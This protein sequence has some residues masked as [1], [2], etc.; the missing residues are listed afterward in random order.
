M[1]KAFCQIYLL[2]VL[3]HCKGIA[4][5]SSN[6]DS[7]AEAHT[8]KEAR[9]SS[10]CLVSTSRRICTSFF[11][12]SESH[13]PDL[14]PTSLQRQ[15]IFAKYCLDY[16][17]QTGP[18]EMQILC[19]HGE[20]R[21][22][23][24]WRMPWTLEYLQRHDLC[25]QEQQEG[26]ALFTEVCATVDRLWTEPPWEEDAA[27]WRH[28]QQSRSPRKRT[29]SPRQ[30]SN[31][32]R[33]RAG[34]G[35]M[36]D[37]FTEG[38]KGFDK[39]KSKGKGVEKG[40]A[41]AFGHLPPSA[42]WMQPPSHPFLEEPQSSSLATTSPAMQPFGRARNEKDKDDAELIALRN[43]ASKVRTQQDEQS[44]DVKKALA[45]VEAHVR[46]DDAKSYHQLVSLVKTAK[47]KLSDI[48]EQ[49]EAFRSQWTQYLDKATKMWTAHIDSYEEGENKFAE[50]R[51]EAATQLQQVRGQLHAIHIRTMEG[52]VTKG[53]LQEGQ[54]ALDAT[55][56]IDDMDNVA[57]QPQFCQLKT[58]LKGAA[59]LLDALCVDSWKG[60]GRVSRRFRRLSFWPT[61]YNVYPQ[62]QWTR[63]T[64]KLLQLPECDVDSN[65]WGL[66]D[67]TVP[68]QH[69][70]TKEKDY[71]DPWTAQI[72]A[73]LL[74]HSL[75][76]DNLSPS[77]DAVFFQPYL[78]DL[79]FPVP[80][81][82]LQELGLCRSPQV[83]PRI[84]DEVLDVREDDLQDSIDSHRPDLNEVPNLRDPPVFSDQ[85][86]DSGERPR[87]H[88]PPLHHF[89]SWVAELWDLLQDEGATE[90]LEEGPIVYV[91][92]YYL[93]HET[94]LRQEQNRPLRLTREY[95][96]WPTLV[97]DVWHDF[98][99]ELSDFS[100]HLV[101]PEPPL[102]VTQGTVG[103]VL[104]VQHPV[105]DQAAVLTTAVFDRLEGHR[106]HEVAHSFPFHTAYDAVLHH[107]DAAEAC[108]ELDQ[109]NLGPCTIRAGRHTFPRHRAIR[110]HDGLGLV[111]R[112]PMAMPEE[113]WERR[114]FDNIAA[115]NADFPQPHFPDDAPETSA[116][117][118]GLQEEPHDESHLMAR[119]P[120]V[121]LNYH[122][123]AG[124]ITPS[125]YSTDMASSS[126]SSSNLQPPAEEWHLCYV[127]ALGQ[128]AL[129]VEV[130][131]QDGEELYRRVAQAFHIEYDDIV[132]VHTILH[133]PDDILHQHRRC[134][135]L[136]RQSDHPPAHFMRLC[137][138][139]V[140]YKF[141]SS[142]PASLIERKVK[143]MPQRS[144][145]DSTIRL[146][147][148][149]GHCSAA[150]DRCWLWHDKQY[151]SVNAEPLQ[152]AHGSYVRLAVPAHPEQAICVTG[153]YL[154]PEE[155][156]EQEDALDFL[157]QEN[158]IFTQLALVHWKITDEDV[159]RH[160]RIE[161][162]VHDTEEPQALIRIH[163]TAAVPRLR[164]D[165]LWE[166][167]NR[168]ALR[169][170]GLQNEPV[171]LFESWY[172]NGLGFPRCSYSRMVALDADVDSWIE[173]LRQVWQDRASPHVPLELAIVHPAVPHARHGGHL[174]V[175]Q[176]VHP[177][178]K[179]SLL[180]SMWASTDGALQDRFAQLVPTVIN[181]QELIHHNDLTVLCEH[182]DYACKAY[183]GDRELN[184]AVRTPVYHGLHLALVIEYTPL[185]AALD[186]F[187]QS[188]DF[189]TTMAAPSHF[190]GHVPNL[191]LPDISVMPRIVQDLHAQWTREAA[192]RTE[193]P[194]PAAIRTWFVDHQDSN[195]RACNRP[196]H[197]RLT[198][199]YD[200]WEAALRQEWR[201]Y[202]SDDDWIDYFI[203][204][205]SPPTSGQAVLCHVL[206]VRHRHVAIATSVLSLY[207]TR[208]A[209]KR[210][211]HYKLL[212]PRWRRSMSNTSSVD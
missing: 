83:H 110:C 98:F 195:L 139:D 118:P 166:L 147:G 88:R 211:Q 177:G 78:N 25:P 13:I 116:V 89:P 122:N 186:T 7:D 81:R 22:E 185:Q 192:A 21:D 37:Q 150:P 49:W 5:N 165:P 134:L 1:C 57:E 200:T 117:A 119:S 174:I 61:V 167:W 189:V 197:V 203:V 92:S 142:G 20:R 155:F 181:L 108:A 73:C 113:E 152:L 190:P 45:A 105:V 90:L 107:A 80:E 42:Q 10:S 39:G 141:D 163:D 36:T 210:D 194:T 160:A 35:Q 76:F 53:E 30:R 148:Y 26:E 156:L 99:D 62:G 191:N 184:D 145:R 175:L 70:V 60:D 168:P 41:A 24:L 102:S 86:D 58:D 209:H 187:L 136:Q 111:V 114:V 169:T 82:D 65:K 17:E 46:K 9:T 161:T 208:T 54:T 94:C 38:D 87:D 127:F 64:C 171:M 40:G 100:L 109:Q 68:P 28:T 149:D 126:S 2:L 47:K 103:V 33:G 50:K 95:H 123:P 27:Q 205:P 130:P 170:R 67:W 179:A 29:Q 176:S 201:D 97:R 178:E 55:M 63:S 133:C 11:T 51:K 135:L 188:E 144:N 196:R 6:H 104:V 32:A 183:I 212:S 112:V 75:V 164:T 71:I 19:P 180:S 74:E 52:T 43:L 182:P 172:L 15:Q 132:S 69:S 198:L 207:L 59:S 91:G 23:S 158:T 193:T 44:E 120:L 18:L 162:C 16:G 72:R 129:E 96:Q 77:L 121:R 101:R 151:I 8:S 153:E 138:I 140:E 154:M 84:L 106:I 146:I 199:M 31:S 159:V 79:K 206:L 131:W 125:E 137:L 143:W 14:E 202:V 173:K 115:A 93:S 128:D 124:D 157:E 66:F 48:E 3:I 12:S 85:S 34:K 56:Q 204:T 4:L